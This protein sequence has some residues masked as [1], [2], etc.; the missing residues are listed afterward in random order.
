[1]RKIPILCLAVLPVAIGAIMA[2]ASEQA[3]PAS[4]EAGGATQT[5]AE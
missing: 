5:T 2:T 3:V 1:M 4:G